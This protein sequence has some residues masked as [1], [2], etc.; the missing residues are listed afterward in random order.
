MAQAGGTSVDDRAFETAKAAIGKKDNMY[1]AAHGLAD[2]LGEAGA[3][4]GPD[5][6]RALV[7]RLAEDDV[8]A[9]LF[10]ISAGLRDIVPD[11]EGFVHIVRRVAGKMRREALQG[12]IVDVL[13]DVGR[14]HPAKAAGAAAR[15]IELGDADYAAYMIGGAYVGARRECDGLVEGLF[16]SGAP[17]DAAAALRALKVASAEHGLPDA[18]RIRAAAERAMAHDD[19]EVQKEA[20]EAL[21]GLCRRGDAAAEAMVES[22][23]LGRYHSRPVL[24][25]NIWRDSPFDDEKSL[26]YLR[27]CMG[28]EGDRYVLHS[29]YWAL[30]KIAGRRPGEVARMM[31]WMSNNG[32][33]HGTLVGAVQDELGKSGAPAAAVAALLEALQ[34][35]LGEKFAERLE[36][37]VVRIARIAGRDK[38]AALVLGTIDERPARLGPCLRVLSLLALDDWR[39][40]GGPE[41]AEGIMSRLCALSAGAGGGAEGGER[42]PELGEIPSMPA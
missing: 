2:L 9:F 15:L 37:A 4:C 32:W 16:S 10:P 30:V 21:L 23:A 5:A 42:G 36:S 34:R 41:F 19:A 6:I 38:V 11:D 7:R 12:P 26:R 39:D 20:M 25:A 33:Y 28:Y 29:V 24:A 31:I 13:A 3:E 22:M 18:G 35:P 1:F 40:G 14:N 27:A 8:Y 17:R